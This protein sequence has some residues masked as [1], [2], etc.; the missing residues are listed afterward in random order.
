MEACC[1]NKY[2]VVSDPA[3]VEMSEITHNSVISAASWLKSEISENITEPSLKN[4]ACYQN[5][6]IFRTRQSESI[7]T[8]SG[9]GHPKEEQK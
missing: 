7:V 8:L 2:D 4:S 6:E 3:G 1:F 9:S 5:E